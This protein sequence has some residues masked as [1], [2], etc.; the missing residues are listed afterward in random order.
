MYLTITFDI[1][2]EFYLFIFVK[3]TEDPLFFYLLQS[4]THIIIKFK[5]PKSRINDDKNLFFTSK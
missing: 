3:F 4:N 5:S 1:L 2:E